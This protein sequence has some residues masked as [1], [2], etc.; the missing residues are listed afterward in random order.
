MTADSPY[1]H[2]MYRHNTRQ[3]GD[4]R[5]NV[6]DPQVPGHTLQEEMQRVPQQTERTEQYQT[7][8]SHCKQRVETHIYFILTTGSNF[9]MNSLNR[10]ANTLQ[11]LN[12]FITQ[13]D[14]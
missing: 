14:L 5:A 3:V 6:P 8:N 9:V 13:I 1:V 7:R 4:C 11:D 12:Q 2:V 10:H